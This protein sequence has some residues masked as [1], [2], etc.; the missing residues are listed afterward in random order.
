MNYES[1]LLGGD[2]I[3]KFLNLVTKS[4]AIVAAMQLDSD[5]FHEAQYC[6][7]KQG[8]SLKGLPSFTKARFTC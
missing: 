1:D 8:G 5:D 6:C 3:V 7:R 2:S 4:M